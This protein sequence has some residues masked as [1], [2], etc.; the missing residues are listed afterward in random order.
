MTDFI[1]K[2][3]A[4]VDRPTRRRLPLMLFLMLMTT[5]ME[6]LGVGIVFPL[7]KLLTDPHS[8]QSNPW[9]SGLAHF[10]GIVDTNVLLITVTL[11]MTALFVG[12]NAL[13]AFTI[14]LQGRFRRDAEL[15]LSRSLLH[16]YLSHPYAALLRRNSAE[17][18][19]NFTNNIPPFVSF[20]L[21]GSLRIVSDVLVVLAIT[22]V[23]LALEPLMTLAVLGGFSLAL[24]AMMTLVR[25]RLLAWGK[26]QTGLSQE[27]LRCL[28][29][30]FGAL[31]D[32]KIS[33]TQDFF[34]R[35]F[36]AAIGTLL[37]IQL[38]VSVAR[39]IPRMAMEII[40]IAA[41]AGIII[42]MIVTGRSGTDAL[43]ILGVFGVAGFRIVPQLNRIV[44]SIGDLRLNVPAVELIAADFQGFIDGSSTAETNERQTF[45]REIRLEKV[46]YSY[47]ETERIVLKDIDLTIPRGALIG[48]VGAS[49]AGKSTLADIILG[50]LRPTNGRM[51]VDGADV[52]DTIIS[53]QRNV[54]TV[55]QD[56]FIIDDTLRYNVALGIP[57]AEID[58]AKVMAALN[59]AQLQDL[60][61]QLGGIDIPVGE[62]GS[63]LSGG[64]RQRLGIA[65]A[66][67]RDPEVLVLDEATSALDVQTEHEVNRVLTGLAGTRTVIVIAHRLSTVRDCDSIVFM[68][69]GRIADMGAFED[70]Q[71]SNPE[72]ARMV[73]LSQ[74]HSEM[75]P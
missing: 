2:S 57:S 20:V 44:G 67:Y 68:A 30:S 4:M 63:R 16:T 26:M 41:M 3:W 75:L 47:P 19:V 70:L 58:D 25:H 36:S 15:N 56:I 27:R 73:Q 13:M 72:F 65:R 7:V 31:R 52:V 51:T 48:L 12:K 46:S 32:I 35:I 69:N 64:Q 21:F 59:Q 5:V 34:V 39:D 55:P 53:W 24:A 28:Q 62:R 74:S 14:L 18:I 29:Y 37:D 23:L 17:L 9:M 45:L 71:Q 1:R 42:G 60:V 43:A 40:M 11:G 33:S 50:L 54:A 38:R 10:F 49:G 22:G 6:A 8:S 66:L 61:T